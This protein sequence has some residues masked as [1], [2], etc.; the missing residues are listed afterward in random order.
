MDTS[1]ERHHTNQDTDPRNDAEVLDAY[2]AG[3]RD[4]LAVLVERYHRPL[5]FAARRV[6]GNDADASDVVQDAWVSVARRAG[7]FGYRSAVSTW[8]WQI[9]RNQALDQRRRRATRPQ[10]PLSDAVDP[11]VPGDTAGAVVDQ[12]VV[13]ELLDRLSPEQRRAMEL[14]Y[15]EDLSTIEAAAVLGVAVGTV[16]SRCNRARQVMLHAA[17]RT[18]RTG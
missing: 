18:D 15:L 5:W 16:K 13:S 6:T 3:D 11:A 10:V 1:A 8:L 2:V 14:V 7:G 9:V 17:R 12:I 4:A